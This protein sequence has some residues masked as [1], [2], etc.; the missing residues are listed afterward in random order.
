MPFLVVAAAAESYQL[1]AHPT[2]VEM[3]QVVVA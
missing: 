3:T 1:V 2:I